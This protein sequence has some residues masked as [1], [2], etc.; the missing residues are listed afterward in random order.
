M[1]IAYLHGLESSID[2]KDPKIIFLNKNFDNVYAPSINYKDDKT[3]NKLYK[4]IKSLNPD[5]IV[6]SSMG[7]Y[8]SYLIGSKLSIP[9]LLFNPAMTGRGFD[10]VVDDSGL[11]KT[12]I[13][14]RFGKSDSV[15]SG[16]AV[17][18]FFKENGVS[19]NHEI[20]NGG[21]RVPAD[22]F[23]NSIKEVL[24]MDE[25]HNK[26]EKSRRSM[27]HVKMFEEFRADLKDEDPRFINIRHFGG[28]IKDIHSWLS[29][30]I[31]ETNPYKDTIM[32]NGPN[33]GEKDNSMPYQ[34]FQ[35]G[36]SDLVK[37]RYGR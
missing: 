29:D 12:K 4:N 32:V 18:S 19:F 24:G 22:V 30:K 7:G 23:I 6:G 17:R 21:H 37:H 25:V 14:I 15:I 35:N 28:T 1:K 26:T 8:V 36:K 5:L 10:P 33:Q 13:N 34:D 20:Y 27:Q 2:Q 16:S 11:K 9:V 31:G 3:F